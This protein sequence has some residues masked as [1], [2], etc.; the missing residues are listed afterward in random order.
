M[1]KLILIGLTL[2]T[3]TAA[4][5]QE[6]TMAQTLSYLNANITD[7]PCLSDWKYK[8]IAYNE[9][10]NAIEIFFDVENGVLKYSVNMNKEYTITDNKEKNYVK[11][12]FKT[13]S[14]TCVDSDDE[15]FYRNYFLF[16]SAIPKTVRAVKHLL[17]LGYANRD[18]TFD[19]IKF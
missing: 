18:T 16:S 7:L 6:P 15:T 5:G 17:K 8:T 14:I 12:E 10:K 2:F 4:I 1:K 3:I 19:D 11:V 13:E 9:S